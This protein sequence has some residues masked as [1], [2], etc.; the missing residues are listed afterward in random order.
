MK[1]PESSVQATRTNRIL[2]VDADSDCLSLLT[3]V[4]DEVDCDVMLAQTSREAF[5]LL[6]SRMHNLKLVVVDVDP[7]AHGL[8][9]LESLNACAERPPIVAISALEETYMCPIA[10]EHG[11]AA[12]LGKPLT[13]EKLRSA[14]RVV[15]QRRLT[16]DRWGSLVPPDKSQDIRGRFRGITEKLSPITKPSPT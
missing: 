9:L 11:A 5:Q 6:R 13:L 7:G 8:A 15:A 12:C 3:K 16:S 14:L 4:S 2:L 10:Q 1:E